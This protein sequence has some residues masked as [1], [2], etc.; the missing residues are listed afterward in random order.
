MTPDFVVIIPAR[1]GS[2][3]LP[4][5]ALADLAGQ[6]MVVR[7]WRQAVASA[8]ARVVVATDNQQIVDVV[9]RAGGEAVM[10]SSEHVS[11]TDRVA[12]VA[13]KL[14]LDAERIVVNVQGDEPFIPPDNIVQVAVNLAANPAMDM[15]TLCEPLDDVLLHDPSAVKVV[16]GADER[17]L[18]FSRATIPW[19]RDA[20]ANDPE[21][22]PPSPLLRRHV[23]IYAYTVGFL[24]RF[25]ALPAC[26]LESAE[27]LE[28]LRALYHGAVIHVA[29]AALPPGPGI[30]TPADLERARALLG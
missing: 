23:G 9:E 18:Y 29:D 12:E 6:P 4:G 15:A 11:G 16:R 25:V 13:R 17:A 21:T 2:T 10:T 3:R 19:Y 7:T 5:K 27:A 14:A 8:A 22:V 30:D 28:Q 26:E 20:F 1:L 24:E